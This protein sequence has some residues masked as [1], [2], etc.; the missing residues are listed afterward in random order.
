MRETPAPPRDFES[1][2]SMIVEQRNTLPKR[3]AQVAAFALRHPDD[4]ALGTAASIAGAAGVQPSTLVRFAQ[5]LGYGG[6]SDLQAIFRA[7]LRHVTASYEE[8]LRSIQTRAGDASPQAALLAGFLDTA[9]M[10]VDGIA[11]SV[12]PAHFQAAVETLAG[13]ETIWLVGRRRSYPVAAYL[14]YAFAQLAI[15]HRMIAS[16][17][18]LDAELAAMATPRDAA[19]AVS[20][21]PYAA[22]TVDHA[23]ALAATGVPLVALTDSAFSPLAACATC[24]LE[25]AE[26]DYEGFRSLSA[27]MALAMAV[28]VGI[29][30]QRNSG[31][32][33]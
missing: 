21:A 19:I 20:F 26:A 2:R 10:S 3:L 11:E 1:L 22:E 4:V 27:T 18:G 32:S 16:A 31:A 29:A 9:R 23:Q 7:R 12:K 14:A 15:P 30:R 25:I 28:P 24:T 33:R 13:A 17:S 6:F 5:H 8:R